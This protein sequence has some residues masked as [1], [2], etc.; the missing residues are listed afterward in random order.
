MADLPFTV[1][2]CLI[3]FANSKVDKFVIA[4]Q[5]LS[6]LHV[7][8]KLNT[9]REVVLTLQRRNE[10]GENI[11]LLREQLEA[12]AGE[13]WRENL[14][15]D[16]ERQRLWV[17][18]IDSANHAY[19]DEENESFCMGLEMLQLVGE[20]ARKTMKHQPTVTSACT[21]HDAATNRFIGMAEAFLRATP[22]QIIAYLMD[23]NNS[24]AVSRRNPEIEVRNDVLESSSDHRTVIY[25]EFKTLPGFD[26]RAILNACIFKRLDQPQPTYMWITVPIAEHPAIGKADMVNVVRAETIRCMRMTAEEE[27]TRLEYA[28][29]LDLKGHFPKWATDKFVLP[30]TMHLPYTLQCYFQVV[31]PLEECTDIDGKY[32]G[33]MLMDLA[34]GCKSKKSLATEVQRFVY[35]SAMLSGT[36][37]A[38][39]AAFFIAIISNFA[40]ASEVAVSTEELHLVTEEEA[41]T[42]GGSLSSMLLAAGYTRVTTISGL[43]SP[44]GLSPRL[45]SPRQNRI[46]DASRKSAQ[47]AAGDFVAKHAATSKLS[48][49]YLWFKPMICVI[50]ERLA[51]ITPT[52]AA[53]I[54][55]RAQSV[56]TDRSRVVP[57]HV[58]TGAE[59]ESPVR[60]LILGPVPARRS[61]RFAAAPL[62]RA[63][64]FDSLAS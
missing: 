54:R 36:D 11:E 29:S 60:T 18:K 9:A 50:A 44:Q 7:G 16:L 8:L 2:N 4:S 37:F 1:L 10:L 58:P 41:R 32:V 17:Q 35:R 24:F 57:L 39:F 64:D 23:Y 25:N 55:Q 28:G 3:I 13:V 33:H 19:D 14:E 31:R 34:E 21:A 27:G 26:N 51:G 45:A 43:L 48:R 15:S 47:A 12:H 46:A 42:M 30:E 53:Q 6:A 5:L 56:F 38:H 22:Q 59:S 62:E 63:P 52:T 40:V 61:M 49:M 20:Q